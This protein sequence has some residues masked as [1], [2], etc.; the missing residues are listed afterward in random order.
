MLPTPERA[1]DACG[2]ATRAPRRPPVRRRT[3]RRDRPRSAGPRA[4]DPPTCVAPPCSPCPRSP[5]VPV[6]LR[7]GRRPHTSR[8]PHR[9]RRSLYCPPRL[10]VQGTTTA[11]K[12]DYKSASPSFTRGNTAPPSRH[13]CPSVLTVKSTSSRLSPWT[14]V[15]PASLVHH[16]TFPATPAAGLAGIRPAASP[17]APLDHI[18][19][20]QIV[21]GSLVQTRGLSVIF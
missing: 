3:A 8:P 12:L 4:V 15:A 9:P 5:R 20:P 6:V 7:T 17:L 14:R 16:Q 18:P 11:S 2:V 1:P 10:G 21:P 13:C 19:K